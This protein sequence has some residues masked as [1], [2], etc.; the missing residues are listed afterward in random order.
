MILT[1]CQFACIDLGHAEPSTNSPNI[2]SGL[3]FLFV[4][5]RMLLQSRTEFLQFQLF[6]TWFSANGVVVIA[7]FFTN[8][9][10]YLRFFL[11]FTFFCHDSTFLFSNANC[12]LFFKKAKI[13]SE[14]S[15]FENP[16]NSQPHDRWNPGFASPIVACRLRYCA[17]QQL[18]RRF[19][20]NNRRFPARHLRRSCCLNVFRCVCQ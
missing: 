1:V 19:R 2:F 6:T 4:V 8:Q 14:N 20:Q 10:H 17:P 13:V 16:L 18:L 15:G 11:A 12:E 9:E 3:F 7:G 5:D